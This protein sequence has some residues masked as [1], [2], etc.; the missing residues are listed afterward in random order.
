MRD[1]RV[2]VNRWRGCRRS[3]SLTAA[4]S[5]ESPGRGH[6]NTKPCSLQLFVITTLIIIDIR[7][8]SV[9]ALVGGGLTH[10]LLVLSAVP[11]Q[12]VC[13]G[14]TCASRRTGTGAAGPEPPDG[15][16]AENHSV[17]DG[18][19][20]KGGG[21]REKPAQVRVGKSDLTK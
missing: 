11:C 13:T 9:T 6:N 16:G 2:V 21:E 14:R 3:G 15:G 12:H 17:G 19:A 18:E 20:E 8:R 7:Y 1:G 5:A 4:V 10:F